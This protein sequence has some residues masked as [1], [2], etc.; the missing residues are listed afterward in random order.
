MIFATSWCAC[1]SVRYSMTLDSEALSMSAIAFE[2]CWE[3][4]SEIIA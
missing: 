4:V 2:G 3:T 1:C